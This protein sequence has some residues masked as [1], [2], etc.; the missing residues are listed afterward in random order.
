MAFL[1]AYLLGAVTTNVAGRRNDSGWTPFGAE[2]ESPTERVSSQE[3]EPLDLPET[4]LWAFVPDLGAATDLLIASEGGGTEIEPSIRDW[5]VGVAI[6][7]QY[8]A[9]APD[10]RVTMHGSTGIATLEF[11]PATGDVALE[12][13]DGA[14]MVTAAFLKPWVQSAASGSDEVLLVRRDESIGVWLDRKYL[15]DVVVGTPERLIVGGSATSSVLGV[16]QAEVTR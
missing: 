11:R 13:K 3:M 7:V 4:L 16:Q 6:T 14:G 2:S 8:S 15:G 9:F 1:G 5:N 12:A 10:G